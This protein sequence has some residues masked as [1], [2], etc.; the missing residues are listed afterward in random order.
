MF[1]QHLSIKFARLEKQ[2]EYMKEH[3]DKADKVLKTVKM[4]MENNKTFAKYAFKVLQGQEQVEDLIEQKII[5][6][7]YIA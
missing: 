4:E 7:P 6:V 3:P 5:Q 2:I 1:S